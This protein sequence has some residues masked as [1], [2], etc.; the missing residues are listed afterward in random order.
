[1]V[2]RKR[3]CPRLRQVRWKPVMWE[4]SR[5]APETLRFPEAPAPC[6]PGVQAPVGRG[7]QALAGGHLQPRGPASPPNTRTQRESCGLEGCVCAGGPAGTWPQGAGTGGLRPRP[8][9]LS[10][11][12]HAS[13]GLLPHTSCAAA[14]LLGAP[15]LYPLPPAHAW[16]QDASRAQAPGCSSTIGVPGCSLGSGHTPQDR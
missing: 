6:R 9:A 14:N 11:G 13:P 16:G 2:R 12:A 3:A 5:G 10:W 7:L 8:D 1:M 4:H 15:V